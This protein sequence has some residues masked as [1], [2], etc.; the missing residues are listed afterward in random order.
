MSTN[1]IIIEIVDRVDSSIAGKIKAIGD[2]ARQAANDLN[3]LQLALNGVSGGAMNLGSALNLVQTPMNNA[4]TSVSQLERGLGNLLSRVVGME[5]GLGRLGGAFGSIGMAAAGAGP[6]IVAAL[7]AAAVIGAILVYEKFEAAARKLIIVQN[8]VAEAQR[9]TADTLLDQKEKLIGLIEGPLAKYQMQLVDLNQKSI[10]VEGLVALN[11]EI[12]AQKSK[13]DLAVGAMERYTLAIPDVR[14]AMSLFQAFSAVL[15][16]HGINW[17]VVAVAAKK[18]FPEILLLEGVLSKIKSTTE[19]I[20]QPFTLQDAQDYINASELE[21]NSSKNTREALINDLAFTEMKIRS[22]TQLKKELNQEGQTEDAKNTDK[23]LNAVKSYYNNLLNAQKENDNQASILRAE[24]N[25]QALA[26]AVKA[27]RERAK[28]QME[29]FDDEMGRFKSSEAGKGTPQA[30]LA[31]RQ[32]QLGG[33]Q[34]SNLIGPSQAALAGNVPKMT[35]EM[36]KLKEEIAKQGSVIDGVIDKYKA[37]VLAT[38]AYTEAQKAA[39]ESTK[40]LSELERQRIPVN[41]QALQ[42]RIKDTATQGEKTREDNKAALILRDYNIGLTDQIALSGKYGQ[43]LTVETQIMALRKS[44]QKDNRDLDE[45][46]QAQLRQSLTLLEQNKIVQRDLNSLWDANAGAV[47]RNTLSQQ[48]LNIAYRE[49]VIT[50]DQLRSGLLNVALAQ[51]K[52]DNELT[53]GNLK[54]SITQV[55]GGLIPLFTVMGTTGHQVFQN[56]LKDAT[57][58]LSTLE[59]GVARGIGQWAAYGGSISKAL[60]DVGR[61]AVAGLISSLIE[62]GLQWLIQQAIMRAFPGLYAALTAADAARKTAQTTASIVSIGAVAVAEGT[63]IAAL[64]GPAWALAEAVSIA[65]FGGADAAAVTGIA[66]VIAAGAIGKGVGLLSLASGGM[67]TGPSGIDKVPAWLTRGE[68]VVNAA[69]TSQNQALLESINSGATATRSNSAPVSVGGTQMQISVVHDGATS[70][71]VQQIDERTVR[72]IAKQESRAA[73]NQYAPSVIASD[74]RDP[75]SRT[76]KAVNLNVV[77]PRRR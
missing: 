54:S 74:L 6:L 49:G 9:K 15:V 38:G 12:D 26:D 7:A 48:A 52:L 3:S 30:E 62:L 68:F 63:A 76:S 43:A 1:P 28:Y 51:N 40:M 18:V 32:A 22:L 56:L 31:L 39:A 27:A 42:Q 72:I 16:Q 10:K 13:W 5:V 75:N 46:Q 50:L 24:A 53:G 71:G 25:K 33:D 47:Q 29:A 11:K 61:Q 21:R 70:I 35:D 36:N 66:A 69:A 2:N 77:A 57:Q 37:S 20:K 45:Q 55:F 44:L 60:L 23:A 67:V 34:R 65:S 73:V 19:G 8:D 14:T 17:D 41:D 58:F 64:M 4:T 59:Q